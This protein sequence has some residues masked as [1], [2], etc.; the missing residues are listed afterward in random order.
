[1]SKYV[2][3][4]IL[5]TVA[6]I[7]FAEEVLP[8][9]DIA[10]A[11][12]NFVRVTLNEEVFVRGPRILLGDLASIEGEGADE[13]AA[14]EITTAPRPGATDRIQAALVETRLRNSRIAPESL[15]LKGPRMIRATTLHKEILGSE[16]GED[17]RN[18]VLAELP[19]DPVDAVVEITAPTYDVIVPDGD[20]RIEWKANPNYRYLGT[21]AFQGSVYVNDLL[22]KT[23]SARVSVEAFDDFVVADRDIPRGTIIRADDLALEKLPLTNAVRGAMHDPGE[24][25]GKVAKTTIFP[26]T[27]L[28]NRKV[29]TPLLVRRHQ[30]VTVISRIGSLVVRTQA[31]SRDDGR[32]GDLI[33]CIEPDTRETLQGVVT[34]NGTVEVN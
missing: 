4:S 23:V 21:T 26:G 18:F 15:E 17:L 31:R 30:T 8:E 20:V 6:A 10:A 33:T 28:T 22:E 9:T 29:D 27:V 1:M 34:A 16:L 11:E 25:I 12:E 32:I 19:W 3:A 5:L 14:L 7:G 24:A 13:L 2:F